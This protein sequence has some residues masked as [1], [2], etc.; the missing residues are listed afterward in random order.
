MQEP[1]HLPR[2]LG[3]TLATA[4]VVG[5]VIGSGVFKKASAVSENISHFGLVLTAWTLVGILTILG[6]LALA[7]VA[8][9][10]GK[11]GG[12]YAILREAYGRWA[13]FLSGWVEFWIVRSGSI[14]ALATI[15]VESL[16]DILRQ[17]HPA[18][19]QVDVF[20]PWMLTAMTATVIAVLAVV[21]ARG[22][23]LGAGLQLVVTT[24][25]VLSLIGIALLPYIAYALATGAEAKPHAARLAPIWPADWG[26]VSW[27]KFGGALVGVFWAYHG[28]MNIAP[29]AEEVTNPRRNIPLALLSGVGIIILLYLCVNLAYYLI[30]PGTEIAELKD[31]TVV[32]EFSYRI[33]GSVGLLFAS[34]AVM[35]SVFGALNGNLLVGPRLLY[36]MGQD[37]LAPRSLSRLHPR[38]ATPALAETVLAGWSIL[39]VLVVGL[40]TT[41]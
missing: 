10:V 34:A 31:R 25:K 7:E 12:N 16:H 40:M 41:S 5:T 13:G 9:I 24:V 8:V 28:W 35:I 22:T 23:R 29:V 3:Y 39:M 38:Y 19:P 11:V 1:N 30:I 27:V 32:G 37:G 15:F 33:L 20:S 17:V 36:A 18:G 14:A 4:I 26:D 6:A 2:V 21:N